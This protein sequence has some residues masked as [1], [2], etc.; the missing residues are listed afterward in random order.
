MNLSKIGRLLFGSKKSKHPDAKYSQ[1]PEEMI[2]SGLLKKSYKGLKV[3]W[4]LTIR[5][6]NSE[7]NQNDILVLTTYKQEPVNI[8]LILNAKEYPGIFYFA[9]GVVIAVKGEI[10]SIQGN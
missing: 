4:N 10:S 2:K 7:I 6:M 1:S 9:P 8:W 5:N 3:A